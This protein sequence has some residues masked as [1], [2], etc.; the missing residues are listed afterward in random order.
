MLLDLATSVAAVNALIAA[1]P[2]LPAE[3]IVPSASGISV[4]LHRGLDDFEAWREALEIPTGEVS[5]HLR[6]GGTTMRADTTFAG[7]SVNLVG[8]SGPLA[9]P[10]A[11][12]A[13]A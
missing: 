6:D 8:Y 5:F 11:I 10:A 2:L 3:E 1:H 12:K 9:Q 4:H 13:V 7:V